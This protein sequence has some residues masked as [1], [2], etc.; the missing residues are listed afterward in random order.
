MVRDSVPSEI[1]VR[2]TGF[3]ANHPRLVVTLVLLFA[4]VAAQ[5]SVAA[6]TEFDGVLTESGS[7]SVDDGP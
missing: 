1:G 3:A 6:A 7:G 5:G 4:L 2:L